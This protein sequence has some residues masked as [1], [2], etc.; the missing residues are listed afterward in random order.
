[1]NEYARFDKQSLYL[2]NLK[3]QASEPLGAVQPKVCQH[4]EYL[5]N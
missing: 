5:K 2:F 4:V 3:F 1:M